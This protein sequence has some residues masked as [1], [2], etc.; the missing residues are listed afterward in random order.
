MCI[1]DEE[2]CDAFVENCEILTIG[3]INMK[4]LIL[5][6]SPH[7]KGTTAL[8]ADEVCVGACQFTR[9]YPFQPLIYKE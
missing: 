5:T 3:G 9:T 6:G 7:S 2:S 1:I 8:L 4:V